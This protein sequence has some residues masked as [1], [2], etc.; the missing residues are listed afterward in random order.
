MIPFC[1]VGRLVAPPAA[2][3]PGWVATLWLIIKGESTGPVVAHRGLCVC[4]WW[5]CQCWGGH[6][7]LSLPFQG[8]QEFE[9][10]VLPIGLLGVM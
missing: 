4:K 8:L 10:L 6:P 7:L 5:D 1:R 2:F 9:R 3:P